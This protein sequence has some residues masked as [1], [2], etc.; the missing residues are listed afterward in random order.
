MTFVGILG[1]LV[2]GTALAWL[3]VGPS[4]VAIF[5]SIFTSMP[6]WFFIMLL[7]AFIIIWRNKK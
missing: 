5:G 3:I 6:P 7:F 1:A 2:T 4:F